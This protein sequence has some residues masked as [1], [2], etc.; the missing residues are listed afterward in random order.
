M[1]KKINW[2]EVL[3][4]AKET[5]NFETLTA[6]LKSEKFA[7]YPASFHKFSSD[8]QEDIIQN[9]LLSLWQSMPVFDE[10][11]GCSSWIK[12]ICYSRYIDYLRKEKNLF[13]TESIELND[14]LDI[15]TSSIEEIEIIHDLNVALDFLKEDETSLLI[16]FKIFGNSLKDLASKFNK[17]ENSLKVRLSRIIQKIS[18]R[19]KD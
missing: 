1:N 18:K 11:L 8:I 14:Y 2:C 7:F 5:Q 6:L 10:Q 19:Y 16:E 9:S 3:K 15:K 17:S 4:D 12:T 13:K